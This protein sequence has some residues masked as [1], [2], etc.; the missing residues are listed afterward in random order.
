MVISNW[1]PY[2]G[3][4]LHAGGIAADITR[5]V[6]KRAGYGVE[7]KDIPWKRALRGTMLGEYDL[8][9]AIWVTPEREESLFFSAPILA[10]R[11]VVV[12]LKAH[13]FTFK[14]LE[15]LRGQKVGVCRGWAYPDAF[16]KADYFQRHEATD[17]DM[18]L[19]KLFHGRF[20]LIVG[21]ELAV[22]FTVNARFKEKAHL[23]RYSAAV[24]SEAPLH[25][26]FSRK[27]AGRNEI[28]A[29]FN[30]TL[31]AM[32]KDGSYTKILVRHGVSTPAP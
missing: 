14:K 18:N 8:I 10:S 25:V 21:E 20:K 28:V 9:P 27:L 31:K 7:T 16:M 30:E 3:K 2:K 22:R 15:D 6:L 24:I 17:L 1:L 11:V 32:R 4:D 12:S 23:L 19:N 5:Q 26:A 29:R 13:N